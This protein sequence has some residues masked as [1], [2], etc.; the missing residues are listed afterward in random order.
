M[1][2]NNDIINDD[3]LIKFKFNDNTIFELNITDSTTIDDVIKYC[4]LQRGELPFDHPEAVPIELIN[5]CKLV[6][7]GKILNN[8]K[9]NILSIEHI[10]DANAVVFC[11]LAKLSR[12]EINSINNNIGPSKSDVKKLICSDKLCDYLSDPFNYINMCITIG[13]SFEITHEQIYGLINSEQMHK[14]IKNKENYNKLIQQLN[15]N[16][17]N[18]VITDNFK[19]NKELEELKSMGF[20][21]EEATKNLLIAFDGD[22]GNVIN[23]L[24]SKF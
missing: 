7:R 12:S 8:M 17:S 9:Q 21:N 5:K 13:Q 20:D 4:V 11:I 6:F 14:Y 2:D 15:S 24:L 23:E 22:I 10:K 16:T 18:Q 3:I 19:Y 1:A